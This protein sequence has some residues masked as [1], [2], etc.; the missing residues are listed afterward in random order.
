MDTFEQ[1]NPKYQKANAVSMVTQNFKKMKNIEFRSTSKMN[2]EYPL[3][4]N[5]RNFQEKE[6]TTAKQDIAKMQNNAQS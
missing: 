2:F 1:C 6:E 4:S 3:N 5:K